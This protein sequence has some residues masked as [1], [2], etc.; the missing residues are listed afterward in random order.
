LE[1]GQFFICRERGNFK[2]D[3]QPKKQPKIQPENQPKIKPKTPETEPE[4]SPD[5]DEPVV[6]SPNVDPEPQASE[7]DF[8]EYKDDFDFLMKRMNESLHKPINYRKF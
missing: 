3:Y 4:W 8:E 1:R 7:D 6:P 5:E 2:R